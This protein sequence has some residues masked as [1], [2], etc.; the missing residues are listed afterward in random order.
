MKKPKKLYMNVRKK[1]ITLVEIKIF[2]I[3]PINALT[4]KTQKV[5][6]FVNPLQSTQGSM[7]ALEELII[8]P[9]KK[10]YI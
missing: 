2:F 7:K 3:Q 8:M 1:D 6:Y 9:M 10:A 4:L 5:L